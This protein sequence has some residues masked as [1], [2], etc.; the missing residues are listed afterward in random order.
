M[1]TYVSA[2]YCKNCNTYFKGHKNPEPCPNCGG[3]TKWKNVI[4]G[5]E[6]DPRCYG[7]FVNITQ[8]ENERYSASLGVPAS[9]IEK[10]KK[11][12]PQ[13]EWKRFGNSFRPKIRNRSEKLKLMKQRGMEEYP[14]NY[15]NKL[16]GDQK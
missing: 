8:K 11:L 2:L 7:S 1:K 6:N 15:F 4:K 16:H 13:A 3:D 12:H 5:S 10:A 14:A 9:Q